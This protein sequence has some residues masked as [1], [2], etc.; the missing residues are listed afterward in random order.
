MSRW[1]AKRPPDFSINAT[2][3]GAA[4]QPIATQGRS[5]R[6]SDWSA[7]LGNPRAGLRPGNQF[8]PAL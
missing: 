4:M 5:Y 3:A 1:A 8:Q 2:I 7:V 6:D